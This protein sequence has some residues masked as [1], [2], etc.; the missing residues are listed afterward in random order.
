M[1]SVLAKTGG[2]LNGPKVMRAARFTVGQ[3]SQRRAGWWM[4]TARLSSQIVIIA[5]VV[6]RA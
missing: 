2:S 1:F 4:P 3:I 6:G 5:K